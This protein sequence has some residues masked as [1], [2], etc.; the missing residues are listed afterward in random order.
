MNLF[1]N[2]LQKINDKLG[3]GD[4]ILI[5]E[6]VDQWY[7]PYTVKSKKLDPNDRS[8]K[9]YTA[10]NAEGNQKE[11]ATN[12]FLPSP[13]IFAKRSENERNSTS[14][15]TNLPNS[16][17]N[18]I[19]TP[20]PNISAG[21]PRRA[22]GLKRR[23]SH[24]L[25]DNLEAN[26]DRFEG[27]DILKLITAEK[28]TCI[29][30]QHPSYM[31]GAY[32]PAVVTETNAYKPGVAGY[33]DIKFYDGTLGQVQPTEILVVPRDYYEKI[34]QKIVE[35]E[36]ADNATFDA[37]KSES[38][39]AVNSS[40]LMNRTDLS[41]ISAQNENFE[42]KFDALRQN[43]RQGDSIL[44]PD[45]NGWYFS[46]QIVSNLGAE[47]DLE[48]KIVVEDTATS[49]QNLLKLKQILPHPKNLSGDDKIRPAKN[50]PILAPHPDP[51]SIS[52]EHGF[53]IGVVTNILDDNKYRVV[54]YD[55][56]SATIDGSN[57]LC[58]SKEMFDLDF[59]KLVENVSSTMHSR[60]S[61]TSVSSTETEK[62]DVLRDSK[63]TTSSMSSIGSY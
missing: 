2:Y 56:S 58:I 11:V 39:A 4:E 3:S 52:H 35:K 45:N 54:F 55:K 53:A 22:K 42:A 36:E 1:E 47:T 27:I 60:K 51:D 7:Y 8:S 34:L 59:K 16:P 26:T 13:G 15:N 20:T 31:E 6:E 37:E 33:Y 14:S 30:A 10:E 5:K 32:A 44:A 41:Q 28:D 18:Q 63:K 23:D 62:P 9:I 48:E 12:Q 57:I 29:M 43:M 50:S 38:E 21:E 40:N 17:N 25:D 61:I 24:M 46:S 49:K 19:K